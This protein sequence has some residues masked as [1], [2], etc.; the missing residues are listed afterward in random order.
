MPFQVIKDRYSDNPEDTE[1][2]STGV[3]GDD[4]DVRKYFNVVFKF[5][6]KVKEM[7]PEQYIRMSPCYSF[8][9][10]LSSAMIQPKHSKYD[11]FRAVKFRMEK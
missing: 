6:K 10:F 7:F 3:V 4:E 9:Q 5:M 1:D 8:G 11:V 2:E